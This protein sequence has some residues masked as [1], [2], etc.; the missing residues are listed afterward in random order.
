MLGSKLK[1]LRESKG[2]MQRQLAALLEIDTAMISKIENGHKPINKTYLATI[3]D[4]YAIPLD[5]LETMWLA[6]SILKRHA[7]NPNFKAALNAILNHLS[8]NRN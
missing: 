1:E 2:L 5:E 3:S 8:P 4:L 7:D 6:D